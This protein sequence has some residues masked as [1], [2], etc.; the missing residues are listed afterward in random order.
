MIQK[1]EK[2]FKMVQIDLK[3]SKVGQ[4][5]YKS[6]QTLDL[7][8]ILSMNIKWALMFVRA[9]HFLYIFSNQPPDLHQLFI[10]PRRSDKKE[11]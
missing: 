5:E 9:V 4:I 10:M 7:A 2:W 8:L 6:S 1:V 3:R 11:R